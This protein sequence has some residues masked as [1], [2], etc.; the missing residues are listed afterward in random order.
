MVSP[1]SQGK[2]TGKDGIHDFSTPTSGGYYFI[3]PK[4]AD[5]GFLGDFLA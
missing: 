2:T 5:G 3:P 1:K 4:P